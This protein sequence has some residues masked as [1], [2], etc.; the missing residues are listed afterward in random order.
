MGYTRPQIRVLI[1]FSYFS[2]KICSWCLKEP[3]R[4]D[5]SFEHTIHMFKLMDKQSI[6]ISPC[7]LFFVCFFF[8]FFFYLLNWPYGLYRVK[9]VER[10]P[11]QRL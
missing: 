9:T 11:T 5:G 2:T 6:A 7:F 3:S 8:C 10:D 4:G 1:I